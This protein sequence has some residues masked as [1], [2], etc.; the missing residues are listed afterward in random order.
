[1]YTPNLSFSS[2]TPLYRLLYLTIRKD[3]LTKELPSGSCLP[4]KRKMAANLGI[5]INT[6]DAAYQQLV[7]EGYLLSR[8]QSGF[9]VK[10][11]SETLSGSYSFEE[12]KENTPP[13]LPVTSD[14]FIDFSP[15]GIDLTQIPVSSLRKRFLPSRKEK[16]G[17]KLRH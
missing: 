5:S 17:G 3:I 4:A 1:M 2:N 6:V 13:S 8:P 7:S 11:I 12:K 14:Y 15:N 9:F 10:D 16:N